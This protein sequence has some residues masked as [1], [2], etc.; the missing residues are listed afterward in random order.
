MRKIYIVY[1]NSDFTEGKGVMLFHCAFSDG[2]EAIKYVEKQ[3]GIFGSSQRVERNRYGCYATANGYDIKE[4]T[5]YEV[6]DDLEKI[7]SDKK[8][9]V[10]LNKLTA[11]ERTLLGLE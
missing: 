1:R 10:A 9:Q 2:E 11:E 7:E 3:Q 4:A 6:G 8:R 5:L